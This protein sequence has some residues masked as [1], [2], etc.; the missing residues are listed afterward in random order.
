MKHYAIQKAVCPLPELTG[1]VFDPE[2]EDFCMDAEY[3]SIENYVWDVSGYMPEARA[4][5]RWDEEGLQVL[6]C[7]LEKEIRANVTEFGGSVCEDSCLEFFLQPFLD[8]DR[9]INFEVNAGGTA[10]IGIG[11]DR[12]GRENLTEEPE[13]MNIRASRHRG[14]WWAVA[15]TVPHALIEKIYGRT[16]QP[17]AKM[18]ANFYKCDESIHPHFGSWSP[19]VHF[20][21]D[22][23]RPEWFGDLTLEPVDKV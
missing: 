15:Y 20:R 8:D 13:G 18:R 4:Y 11:P 9:Y 19:V 17:G 16:I 23:H 12:H 14:G 7:A 10:L 5:V 22:F 6:M 3:A 2:M 1:D 21:P